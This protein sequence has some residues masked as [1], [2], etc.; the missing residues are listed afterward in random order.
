M[1][2]V[3]AHDATHENIGRLP[4][5]QAAGYT[6]GSAGVRWTSAD[7]AAHRGAVRIDQDFAAS[8]PSADVLDVERGAATFADCPVWAKKAMADFA[9]GARPGQREPAIYFSASNVHL[10]VNAL[11]NGGVRSGVGLYVAS[12]GIGEQEAMSEVEQASGP[13]PIIGV[14]YSSGVFYDY[15]VFSATWLNH[16]SQSPDHSPGPVRHQAG[17]AEP[18]SLWRYAEIRHTTLDAIVAL[19]RPLLNTENLAVMNA[20]LAL[21]DALVAAGRSHPVMPEGLV[22]YTRS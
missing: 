12:W 18:I 4:S 6:T 17:A 11:V 20:Y 21:D 1:N 22:Y 14:Q 9:S 3:V 5:G 2:I 10:V 8:D 7:W 16:V 13:F 19:S 15:D